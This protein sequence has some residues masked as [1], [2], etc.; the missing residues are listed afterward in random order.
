V[1]AYPDRFR[2][3]ANLGLWNIEASVSELERCIDEL[4]FVGLQVFPFAGCSKP[5]VDPS[6]KPIW[7]MLDKKGVPLIFH[8]GS[9]AN[10]D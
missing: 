3:I 7:Q 2:G 5:I 6:F 4:G 9:P 8:P 1:A 10:N